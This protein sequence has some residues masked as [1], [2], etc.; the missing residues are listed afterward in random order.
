MCDE[1]RVTMVGSNHSSISRLEHRKNRCSSPNFS[2]HWLLHN[3]NCSRMMQFVDKNKHSSC[4]SRNPNIALN[5][6]QDIDTV[7]RKI[8]II[9]MIQNTD[10]PQHIWPWYI[11]KCAKDLEK[12]DQWVLDQGNY[13][14]FSASIVHR[15]TQTMSWWWYWS[16]MKA[17][18]FYHF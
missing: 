10:K 16:K 13:V 14:I 6:Y 17:L 2:L 9:N 4:K 1:N 18:F 12:Y 3:V 7:S 5:K 8:N 15:M 11:R